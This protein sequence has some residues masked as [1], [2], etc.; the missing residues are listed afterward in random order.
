VNISANGDGCV[1]GDNI[2][3]EG[4][5]AAATRDLELFD[6]LVCGCVNEFGIPEHI[7]VCIA[8]D[9][10]KHG[11]NGEVIDGQAGSTNYTSSDRLDVTERG[12]DISGRGCDITK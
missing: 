9:G 7:G 8:R 11:G 2:C 12:C 1:F 4:K 5:T 6:A 10:M 3:P